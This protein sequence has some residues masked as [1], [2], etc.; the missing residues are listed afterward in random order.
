MAG[1]VGTTSAWT[2]VKLLNS[3]EGVWNSGATTIMTKIAD[4]S[5]N[6]FYY[7]LDSSGVTD[8]DGNYYFRIYV[9]DDGKFYGSYENDFKILDYTNY[10]GKESEYSFKLETD[11]SSKYI[12]SVG[13]W[14]ST[15]H[16]TATTYSGTGTITFVNTSNFSKPCAYVYC[17]GE[18]RLTGGWPG[19]EMTQ[20]ADG[21]YSLSNV[22]IGKTSKV[23]ISDNGAS[24]IADQV[25][26]DDLV[27]DGNG[28]A[29]DQTITMNEYG[30]ATFCS[31][32]PLDFSTVSPAGLTAYIITAANKTTGILTTEAVTK[33]PANTGL[34]IEGTANASY[35]VT[36]IVTASDVSGNMLVGVTTNTSIGQENTNY[37]FT[38]NGENGDVS[39]P[40]F[41]KVNQNGNTVTAGKA[42]LVVP[43]SAR[44]SFW[45]DNEANSIDGVA[46]DSQFEG[47]TYNLAGQRVAQPTKGLYIVNGKKVIKK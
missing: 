3:I 22:N 7:I 47:L 30:K 11:K 12:I 25:F 9:T 15:W 14:E 13:Y 8:Q 39:T 44:Q 38:V 33:V 1:F 20:N 45:F 6:Y 16:F 46:Q 27:I 26:T 5:N 43:N 42:Y 41:F 28:T 17:T 24:Q 18:A 4:G 10:G 34:Y 21:T 29:S 2:T 23:I 40:K 36:P 35:S 31:K 32:Y 19:T 37:I